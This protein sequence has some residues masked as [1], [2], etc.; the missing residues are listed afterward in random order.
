MP[1]LIGGNLE[2]RLLTFVAQLVSPKVELLQCWRGSQLRWDG[3]CQQQ[4]RSWLTWDF[5]GYFLLVEALVHVN[6]GQTTC[7]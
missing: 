5:G 7:F 4:V 2:V 1:Y 3:A 6:A